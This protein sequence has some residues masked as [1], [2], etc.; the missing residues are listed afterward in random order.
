MAS[1]LYWIDGAVVLA[2][3]QSGDFAEWLD[4]A[5]VL[6]LPEQAA[7][8]RD[9]SLPVDSEAA[10]IVL[11]RDESLPVE[12]GTTLARDESLPV[13][14]PGTT[15]ITLTRDEALPVDSIVQFEVLGFVLGPGGAPFVRS[16]VVPVFS[17]DGH[18]KTRQKKMPK[19]K[20]RGLGYTV[21]PMVNPGVT[22]L[23]I[24]AK[25]PTQR[26]R[27]RTETLRLPHF[28]RHRVAKHFIIP[29]DVYLPEPARRYVL[30]EAHDPELEL[31]LVLGVL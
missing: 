23:A 4:G 11:T 29:R 31:L 16:D 27:T 14:I 3:G 24:N 1:F 18:L 12:I 20:K 19:R 7:I 30:D 28:T 8:T 5:P 26:Q 10:K 22:G 17:Q 21:E 13:E 9:E 6:V 2:I 25:P 15:V